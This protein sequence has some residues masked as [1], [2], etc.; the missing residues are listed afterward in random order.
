MREGG[1]GQFEEQ[2]SLGLTRLSGSVRANSSLW[3]RTACLNVNT[4]WGSEDVQCIR[5][6]ARRYERDPDWHGAAEPFTSV[7][8]INTAALTERAHSTRT[9]HWNFTKEVIFTNIHVTVKK[10]IQVSLQALKHYKI[11]TPIFHSRCFG[12]SSPLKL[13]VSTQKRFSSTTH[14]IYFVTATKNTASSVMKHY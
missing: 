1:G 12:A 13:M 4:A 7:E 9:T 3:K 8:I 6:A 14:R 11:W 2:A 10:R 5:Y